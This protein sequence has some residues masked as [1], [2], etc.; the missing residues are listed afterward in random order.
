MSGTWKEGWPRD[1]QLLFEI[2]VWIQAMWRIYL[3]KN[4]EYLEER[5]KE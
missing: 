4:G 3:K 5:F 1:T 2:Y